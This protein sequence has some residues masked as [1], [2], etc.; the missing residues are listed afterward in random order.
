M[1][2]RPEFGQL[3]TPA[4]NKPASRAKS[5]QCILKFAFSCAGVI[6]GAPKFILTVHFTDCCATI[7]LKEH[8][9]RS[10]K[11]RAADIAMNHALVRGPVLDTQ[12]EISVIVLEQ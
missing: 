5:Q 4:T 8:A 3:T 1:R 2:E 9:N 12:Y 10:P 6:P 7:V 11:M